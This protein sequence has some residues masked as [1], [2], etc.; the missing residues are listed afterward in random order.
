MTRWWSTRQ[1]QAAFKPVI[2]AAQRCRG[3]CWL[4]FRHHPGHRD[5]ESTSTVDQKALGKI[6]GQWLVKEVAEMAARILEVRGVSGTS[7]RS[8]TGTKAIQEVWRASAK[9]WDT[10]R[11]HRQ[12]TIRRRRSVGRTR[13]AVHNA[14]VSDGIH[15]AGA[16]TAVSTAP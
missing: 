12:W 4:R 3:S 14:N 1:N 8:A 15:R 13:I 7:V 9:K 11:G 6:I 2:K 5:R 10:V 16:D